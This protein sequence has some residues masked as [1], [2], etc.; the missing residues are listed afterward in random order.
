MQLERKAL[1]NLLKYHHPEEA[2]LW[3]RADLRPHT[4]ASL[5]ASLRALGPIFDESSFRSFAEEC[6]SPEEFAGELAEDPEIEDQIFLIIFELWRRL[7]PAK[8]SF[9]LIADELDEQIHRYNQGL[10]D[11][12]L[13]KSLYL[14]IDALQCGLDKGLPVEDLHTLLET[15]TAY[16]V[17]GFIYDYIQDALDE[18]DA[19]LAAELLEAF[20]PFIKETSWF[21]L[22]SLRLLIQENPE[23]AEELL[24]EV[25]EIAGELQDPEFHL[26]LLSLLSCYGDKGAF[27]E[28]A[29]DTLSLI[30]TEDQFQEF[31]SLIALFWRSLDLETKEEAA[32]HLLKARK[33][34]PHNTALSSHEKDKV[35]L[36]IT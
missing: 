27:L 4:L 6:E 35:R 33:H 7:M 23:E 1:Y 31:L 10:R 11:E 32:L 20:D 13:L 28:L 12:N 18:E 9:S 29:G 8:K 25:Y 2:K 17:E 14:V 3:Q 21:T 16:D 15:N 30:E 5:F 24:T 22:L 36:L 26:E 34:I 19:K